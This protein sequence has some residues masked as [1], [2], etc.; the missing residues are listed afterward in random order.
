MVFW[1]RVRTLKR[2]VEPPSS[3]S[4]V[5]VIVMPAG[6]K[7]DLATPSTFVGDE[8]DERARRR[9]P[10]HPKLLGYML[11]LVRVS[12]RLRSRIS[13]GLSPTLKRAP[14]RTVFAVAH[15]EHQHTRRSRVCDACDVCA[16]AFVAFGGG[17]KVASTTSLMALAECHPPY[18]SFYINVK[19]LPAHSKTLNG[20][21]H[22]PH[23]MKMTCMD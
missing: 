14:H 11:L 1:V 7:R 9:R 19:L 2:V 21:H 16:C 4:L 10:A 5:V 20:T 15:G 6:N 8:C 18:T 3:T 12:V 22:T 17:Y 13:I 23:L